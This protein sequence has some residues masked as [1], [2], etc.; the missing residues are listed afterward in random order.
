MLGAVTFLLAVHVG[1][2]NQVA[3]LENEI[4]DYTAKVTELETMVEG[5][6]EDKSVQVA[7]LQEKI[8]GYQKQVAK[9]EAEIEKIRE[10][11]LAAVTELKSVVEQSSEGESAQIADLQEKISGYQKQVAKLEAEIEKIREDYLAAVTAL[12]SEVA[13][14][15]EDNAARIAELKAHSEQ[16]WNTEI[17]PLKKRLAELETGSY[18]LNVA[19][20]N[21]EEAFT[22][23]T[24]AVRDQRQRAADK[25]EE[26]VN[27]QQDYLAGT[28]SRDEYQES[29]RQLQVEL[30]KAQLA[31]D[32]D[33]I[34]RMIQS[35]GFSD[36]R[37]DL[38]RL[39]EEAQP[40]LDELGSLL[41]SVKIGA[42]D[43]Q[44]FENRY[45]QVDNAFTQ[46][47]GLLTQVATTKIVEAANTIAADNGYDLVLRSKNVIIYR[48]TARLTDITDI[49]KSELS[50][51]LM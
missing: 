41:D 1:V 17:E 43:P 29:L 15:S 16:V 31:I 27:L 25:Q 7:D 49:V 28:I 35:S 36:I 45:T 50:E 47:D 37:S 24:D 18:A 11:S 23:F 40:V 39:K 30:L 34:D 20:L 4:S 33:I 51:Y 14:A 19:Y 5:I 46:L 8:S 44:E 38:E 48:N 10:D 32:M 2:K 3:E 42:V 12:E 9:L 13:Q 26:I 21:A 6:S 22:V